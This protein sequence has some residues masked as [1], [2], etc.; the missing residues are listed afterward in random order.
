[1][2]SLSQKSPVG[3]ETQL[4]EQDGESRGG[5]SGHIRVYK[6]TDVVK[7]TVHSGTP[8]SVPSS[9]SVLIGIAAGIAPTR[10]GGN[11]AGL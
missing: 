3:V 1:M 2:N 6:V 9:S 5:R 8:W 4:V 10:Y 11:A 7:M